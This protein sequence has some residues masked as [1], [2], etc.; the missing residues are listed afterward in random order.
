MLI[1]AAAAAVFPAL[2]TAVPLTIC[3]APS[4]IKVTGTGHV[5]IPDNASVHEKPTVTDVLFQPKP[6]AGGKGVA[7]IA[8]A[9]LSRLIV[10]D[11]EAV[12]PALSVA[13]PRTS[14]L[15][16]SVL[17]VTGAEQEAMPDVL[18]EQVNV[19]T[20]LVLFQPKASAAGFANAEIVGG[21]LST[22]MIEMVRLLP[23]M[24]R[25][26]TSILLLARR[27]TARS[28]TLRKGSKLFGLRIWTPLRETTAL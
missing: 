14:W 21:T 6:F 12:F 2:S 4:A 25:S 23:G 22:P 10:T 5:A 7:A 8:G 16:P 11:A 20:T 13:V 9:V 3:L 24:L 26:C 17:T 1:N 28:I 27:V 18:S 19:T 15:A